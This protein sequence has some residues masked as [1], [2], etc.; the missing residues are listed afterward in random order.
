MPTTSCRPRALDLAFLGGQSNPQ[1]ATYLATRTVPNSHLHTP[2]RTYVTSASGRSSKFSSTVNLSADAE[3][4]SPPSGSHA[5]ISAV[6]C[7]D[8]WQPLWQWDANGNLHTY[9]P[10]TRLSGDQH[11]L[12]C[13]RLVNRTSAAAQCSFL[14][15]R[16]FGTRDAVNDDYLC[17]LF[18][19]LS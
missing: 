2:K 14:L 5:V 10:S 4:A 3:N 19:G 8:P 15:I 6:L 7:L 1:L 12:L 18:L 13:T 9:I 11:N 16:L 17:N